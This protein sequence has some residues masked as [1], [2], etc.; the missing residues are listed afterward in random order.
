M[1]KVWRAKNKVN[2]TKNHCFSSRMPCIY[3]LIHKQT[4]RTDLSACNEYPIERLASSQIR[5]W[6][7]QGGLWS[8]KENPEINFFSINAA[9]IHST[10]NHW[11][12][13]ENKND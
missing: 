5:A 9:K 4:L 10:R 12:N 11:Q 3:Y 2:W 1:R 7:L 8:A 13:S 6:P